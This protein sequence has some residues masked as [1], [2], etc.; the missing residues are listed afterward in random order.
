M[1][2]PPIRGAFVAHAQ[3]TTPNLPRAEGTPHLETNPHPSTPINWIHPQAHPYRLTSRSTLRCRSSHLKN[4]QDSPTP[5]PTRYSPSNSNPALRGPCKPQYPHRTPSSL[6]K[7]LTHT[8][9]LRASMVFSKETIQV[10]SQETTT[11]YLSTARRTPI[12]SN[13]KTQPI[14]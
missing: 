14:L 8:H 5:R 6:Q 1:V 3:I 2:T 12:S 4:V 10:Q 7:Y 9:T 11:T 13:Y